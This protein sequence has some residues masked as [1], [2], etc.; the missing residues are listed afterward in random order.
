MPDAIL[1][2][3]VEQ[4]GEQGTVVDV[5][6]GYLR[7]YLMPRKLAQ[8]A[9][10]GAVEVI[11]QRQE[12]AERAERNAIERAEEN[13]NLL[14]RTVLTIPQQAGADGRL[15]GSVTAQD[16]ASAIKEARGL[17]LDKRNVHLPEPIKNVGTYMVVVDVVDGVTA[18]IKT[19]VVAKK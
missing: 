3:D 15:F 16:I 6:K 1:L 13:V 5:S 12:A 18:T 7:N 8:P 2:Q 14:N 19:M 4:L 10:R 9:T 17:K 11:R